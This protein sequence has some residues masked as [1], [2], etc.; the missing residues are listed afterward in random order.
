MGGRCGDRADGLPIGFG[1]DVTT[2][3]RAEIALASEPTLFEKRAQLCFSKRW[4]T[5]ER[6]GGKTAPDAAPNQ[7]WRFRLRPDEP[8]VV[9]Q[10]N[11]A[12]VCH[13]LVARW[14]GTRGETR[15]GAQHSSVAVLAQ[16]RQHFPPGWQPCDGHLCERLVGRVEFQS[17]VFYVHQSRHGQEDG[18][19][20]GL[21]RIA[22][23]IA[24]LDDGAR[25]ARH[26]AVAGAVH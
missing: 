9:Y 1:P 2:V 14:L 19:G 5:L 4:T 18:L 26:G 8:Q 6:Q 22:M 25:L 21:V 12:W 16:A 20:L 17:L 24:I 11:V 15:Q 13:G 23:A 7:P 3:S 10:T